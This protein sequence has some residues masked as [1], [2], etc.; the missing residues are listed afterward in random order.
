MLHL[1]LHHRE[2][3]KISLVGTLLSFVLAIGT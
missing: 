3:Q 1:P 2:T